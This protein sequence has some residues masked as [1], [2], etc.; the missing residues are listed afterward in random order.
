[1][2]LADVVRSGVALAN[3]VTDDLQVDVTHDAWTT[4]ALDGKPTYNGGGAGVARSSIVEYKQSRRWSALLGQT[5]DY[6]VKVTILGPVAGN[7]AAGRN[8]P[9]DS[10]DRFT[11]LDGTARPVVDVV[12]IQDPSTGKPYMYEVYLA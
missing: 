6:A 10:R 5:V 3:R 11:L 4:R 8:E 7:G 1:M 9:I 2:G 12:G